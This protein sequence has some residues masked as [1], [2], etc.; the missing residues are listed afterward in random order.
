MRK[1]SDLN[2]TQVKVVHDIGH[3]NLFEEGD[4]GVVLALKER[5]APGVCWLIEQLH[6]NL[7]AVITTCPSS[8]CPSQSE[9]SSLETQRTLK[10]V[11]CLTRFLP[12]N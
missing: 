11:K 4:V 6:Q 9:F 1:I 2:I 7:L 12:T 10:E 8:Q 3:E 5:V